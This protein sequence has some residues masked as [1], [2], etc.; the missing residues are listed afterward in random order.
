MAEINDGIYTINE[1]RN[2]GVLKL[3]P[4]FIVS[5]NGRNDARVVTSK[6]TTSASEE[7]SYAASFQDIKFRS[8][9][10]A[11]NSS[12]SVVPGSGGCTLTFVCP[13]YDSLNQSFYITQ[14]NGVKVPFFST[15]MEVRVYAKGRFMRRDGGDF[16]PSY[17]PVFWG[18]ITSVNESSN[19]SETIFNLSCR[20]MLGW[21]EYQNV[22]VVAAAPNE[23]WGGASVPSTGSLYRFMN[24]W[25][26]ILNLFRETGFDNFIFPSLLAV[27]TVPPELGL[28]ASAMSKNA[29]D[30]GLW[31]MLSG[32]VIDSWLGRYGIGKRDS[33]AGKRDAAFSNLELFGVSKVIDLSDAANS[34]FVADENAEDAFR[35][36]KDPLVPDSETTANRTNLNGGTD[37]NSKSVSKAQ[38]TGDRVYRAKKFQ[39]LSHDIKM[40]FSV[41]GRVLPFGS[42]DSYNIGTEPVRMTKLEVAAHAADG[43]HF[44]FFQDTNGMFVFKPPFYN[45][46]TSRNPVYVIKAGDIIDQQYAEDSSQIVTF[47][48]ASGPVLMLTTGP[49]YST[50]HA[51]FGLMKQYGIREKTVKLAYGNSPDE[52]RAMAAG[53]MART[54]AKAFTGS[55][56]IPF[57]PELRLGY[58]VYI[59]HMDTYYYVTN[60]QHSLT[61]GN[62]STTTLTLEAKRSRIYDSQGNLLRG[63]IQRSFATADKTDRTKEAL[64]SEQISTFKR[65]MGSEGFKNTRNAQGLLGSLEQLNESLESTQ[66]STDTSYFKQSM[67]PSERYY[68]QGGFISSPEPGF[69][70]IVQS[71]FFKKLSTSTSDTAKQTNNGDASRQSSLQ[72]DINKGALTELTHFTGDTLPYTD[73]NGF[74]HIGGFPYGANVVVKPDGGLA[75]YQS[76]YGNNMAFRAQELDSDDKAGDVKNIDPAKAEFLG[77]NGDAS[78]TPPKRS[79]SSDALMGASSTTST[80]REEVK[81]NANSEDIR[82]SQRKEAGTNAPSI[83]AIQEINGGL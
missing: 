65:H 56:T 64:R 47:I 33:T 34:P 73:V 61:M 11:F 40:D 52:L 39:D 38:S 23:R 30:L 7:G 45:M 3:A 9:L 59:D 41:F 71:D 26:I 32:G 29:Q 80:T 21:W 14:P 67:T 44:E 15:M 46:D 78:S 12:A 27:G 57:R 53:E 76:F 43:I 74:Y 20:D 49:D 51:D 2:K 82:K 77:E 35:S 8:G 5:V 36:H 17:Y 19:S 24:P 81:K 79:T 62:T 6:S 69:Y 42:L 55:L 83:R 37:E 48:E 22:N 31:E 68:Q 60:I 10:T 66:D 4:D 75:D 70:R 28:P 18:F 58:P 16:I 25:E 54:N 1:F 50:T 13:Q 63:Y 72:E